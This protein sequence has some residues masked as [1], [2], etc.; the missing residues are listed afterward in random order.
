M[1]FNTWSI[2]ELYLL[3]LPPSFL[4][5]VLTC[6]LCAF[7]VFAGKQNFF[8]FDGD[9]GKLSE[10]HD[11]TVLFGDFEELFAPADSSVTQGFL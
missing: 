8:G 3:Y 9:C 7:L 10:E 6:E 1:H 2:I 4:G 11:E 5:L